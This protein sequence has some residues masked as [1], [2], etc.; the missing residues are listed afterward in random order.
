VKPASEERRDY[1]PVGRGGEAAFQKKGALLFVRRARRAL[2][3]W[4]QR[5]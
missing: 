4:R 3:S 2:C 1:V 5:S